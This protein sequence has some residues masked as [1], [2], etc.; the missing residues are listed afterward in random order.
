MQDHTGASHAAA[1]CL[2]EAENN[3]S[4]TH[5]E[6]ISKKTKNYISAFKKASVLCSAVC[7]RAVCSYM[8]EARGPRINFVQK[9]LCHTGCMI[10][11]RSWSF[12]L[13][14][15]TEVFRSSN[16]HSVLVM[17]PNQLKL[18]RRNENAMLNRL[19]PFSKGFLEK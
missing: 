4:T 12:F 17:T 10:C 16:R 18:C 5:L 3:T 14:N 19:V 11:V 9:S 15:K 6:D 8:C 2:D 7:M 13:T 1:F